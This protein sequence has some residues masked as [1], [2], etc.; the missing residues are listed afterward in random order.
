MPKHIAI[1]Y[2]KKNN[3]YE[4]VPF[5]TEDFEVIIQGAKGKVYYSSSKFNKEKDL[6]NEKMVELVC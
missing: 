4:R 2:D 1:V 3:K 5:N 6:K